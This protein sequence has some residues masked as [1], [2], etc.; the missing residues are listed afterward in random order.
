MCGQFTPDK[1]PVLAEGKGSLSQKWCGAGRK[2]CGDRRPSLPAWQRPNKSTATTELHR[3]VKTIHL[4]EKKPQENVFVTLGIIY[5]FLCGDCEAIPL[6]SVLGLLLLTAHP[7]VRRPHWTSVCEVAN[8]LPM[9]HPRP[10][11]YLHFKHFFPFTENHVHRVRIPV[12]TAS[13]GVGRP[14][15]R[16]VCEPSPRPPCWT[17]VPGASCAVPGRLGT[18]VGRAVRAGRPP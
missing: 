7:P 1:T 13:H 16:P 17:R 15:S 12:D 3:G 11:R 2:V 8:A 4:P 5:G 14:R 6:E 18:R 9:S 10:Q